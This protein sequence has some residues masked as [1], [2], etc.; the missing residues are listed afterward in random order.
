MRRKQIP[1]A[2]VQPTPRRGHHHADHPPW[3]L[4]HEAAVWNESVPATPN[5]S[6]LCGWIC[7]WLGQR[8]HELPIFTAADKQS[9]STIQNPYTYSLNTIAL[10]LSSAINET[11]EIVEDDSL[12]D[13]VETE[14]KRVRL[15]AELAINV[16]RFCEAAIKQLLYCTTF[17][18]ARYERASL[19]QLLSKNCQE[20][21]DAGA[22][23]HD[24]SLLGALAHRYMLCL[25]Y[26]HCA[27]DHLQ[28]I[29]RRRNAEAAHADSPALNPRT[30]AES[31]H[32]LRAS[33]LTLGHSLGHMADH[34]SKIE[35]KMIKELELVIHHYPKRPPYEALLRVSC[36]TIEHYYPEVLVTK[37]PP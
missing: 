13:P 32:D 1:G 35:A 17:K 3:T 36:R 5:L 4:R 7:A 10:S 33:L 34:I 15:E 37:R 9:S 14:I 30:A 31:R 24:V 19:Q 20:C 11:W 21:T 25:E 16:A 26:E 23:G 22:P 27:F 6:P 18:Q 8:V 2:S 29:A 28:V 12:D